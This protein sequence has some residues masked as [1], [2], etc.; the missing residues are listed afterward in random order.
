MTTALHPFIVA[1]EPHMASDGST[2][3]LAAGSVAP[4]GSNEINGAPKARA[5]KFRSKYKHVEAL[6]RTSRP[7]VLS[8]DSKQ[9]PSFLGF[10]N[11]MVLTIS[12]CSC[13]GT[14]G[15]PES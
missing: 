11:L 13:G 6:H 8:H 5:T 4:A 2:G 9:A 1:T 15:H 14:R 10:R 12:E 7:S 3:S